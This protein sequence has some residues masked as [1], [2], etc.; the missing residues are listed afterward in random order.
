MM[1]YIPWI[2][3]SECRIT[4]WTMANLLHGEIRNASVLAFRSR[5]GAS[6]HQKDDGKGRVDKVTLEHHVISSGSLSFRNIIAKKRTAPNFDPQVVFVWDYKKS[7]TQ[8]PFKDAKDP[9]SI[10]VYLDKCLT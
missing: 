4:I 2:K 7:T 3:S 1:D 6:S 8:T 5:R 10:V 9:I